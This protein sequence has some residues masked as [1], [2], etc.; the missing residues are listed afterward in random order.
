MNNNETVV[1]LV[2]GDLHGRIPNIHSQ[3]FDAIISPGD[4]CGDD[5]KE[6]FIQYENEKNRY[7][8]F[9]SFL[10]SNLKLLEEKQRKSLQKG[11]LILNYLSSFNKPVFLVPGN[12]DFSKYCDGI[13]HDVSLG[14][15]DNPFETLVNK[16]FN[17]YNLEQTSMNFRGVTIIGYGSTSAPEILFEEQLHSK[18]NQEL[19]ELCQRYEFFAHVNETLTTLFTKTSNPLLYLTHNPPYG[20]S[21]DII[22]NNNSEELDN[23]HNGSILSRFLIED[24]SPILCISGHIHERYGSDYINSTYCINSGFGEDVNTLVTINTSNN[25]IEKVEFLGNN[26]L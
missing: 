5:I 9:E 11:E 13:N 16:Y 4:I 1:F 24:F 25:S 26:I 17:V 7:K 14:G 6:L 8:S 12:W 21:L 2:V 3:Q 20:C 10:S 22:S 18:D 15:D 23:N 19:E